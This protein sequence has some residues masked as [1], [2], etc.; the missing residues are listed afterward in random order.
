MMIEQFAAMTRSRSNP[1]AE[2]TVRLNTMSVGIG[3]MP[4]LILVLFASLVLFGTGCSQPSLEQRVASL[5][6]FRDYRAKPYI[7][8]ASD[9]QALGQS[10][11]C[12][13]LMKVATTNR[14][15]WE[16]II[17][18]RMLFTNRPAGDFRRA[19]IGAFNFVGDTDYADWPREPIEIVAGVPFFMA[20][21]C[22]G[23]GQPE[24]ADMYLN[25]CMTNCA[26]SPQRYAPKT[27]AELQVALSKLIASTKWKV[28]LS[29]GEKQFLTHQLR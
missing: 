26:W 20:T 22:Q 8:V 12:D 9:L 6:E 14:S 29:A 2:K 28:P 25:Y 3:T 21:R 7:A 24:P 18:C 19:R 4:N 13:T 23:D 10:A 5:P 27:P 16:V 1:P 11:A 15:G 17:L